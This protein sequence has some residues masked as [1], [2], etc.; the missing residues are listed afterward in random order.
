[1]ELMIA[2]GISPALLTLRRI[3]VQEAMVEAI[4]SNSNV[5]YMPMEMMSSTTNFRKIK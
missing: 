2:S 3:E 5:I 4:K 1:M